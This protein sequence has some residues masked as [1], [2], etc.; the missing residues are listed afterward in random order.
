MPET[1][2]FVLNREPV[3]L[4]LDGDRKLLWVL[5]SDL[6]LTGTKYGC[7]KLHCGACT[8]LVDGAAVRETY[9]AARSDALKIS[10]TP[11]D[12]AG[13]IAALAGDNP[14]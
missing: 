9:A 6:G 11:A 8:I 7:G 1:I 3:T 13:I 14:T 10:S 4:T 12:V 2:S 5:R